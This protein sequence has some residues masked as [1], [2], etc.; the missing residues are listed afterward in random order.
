MNAV[1]G[2]LLDRPLDVHATEF[3]TSNM[4]TETPLDHAMGEH[5]LH[6]ISDDEDMVD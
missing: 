1:D 5:H 3:E 6:K 2:A 4:N